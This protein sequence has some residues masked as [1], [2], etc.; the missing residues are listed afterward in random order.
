MPSSPVKTIAMSF[1][2]PASPKPVIDPKLLYKQC[3]EQG[4][5][6]QS[7]FG[8]ANEFINPLGKGPGLGMILLTREDY[9]AIGGDETCDL[10][11]KTGDTNDTIKN[12]QII[13]A[14]CCDP[15][16]ESDASACYYVEVADKRYQWAR[17]PCSRRYNM[18]TADGEDY[19]DDTVNGDI[20]Y[21][22][23]EMLADLWDLA[24][25]D[26][27]PAPTLD[28]AP[29]GTPENF[30]FQEDYALDALCVVLDRLGYALRW[31]PWATSNAYDAVRLGKDLANEVN[32]ERS[33]HP[34]PWIWDDYALR[35]TVTHI[36][37]KV[38]VLFR[39]YPADCDEARF[40]EV[41]VPRTQPIP[42]GEVRE[43]D[44]TMIIHDDLIA[45]RDTASGSG[46]TNASGSYCSGSVSGSYCPGMDGCC[47]FLNADELQA[48]A[49]ERARDF[50]RMATQSSTPF[51]RVYSGAKH[52]LPQSRYKAIHWQEWGQG[53]KTT[54]YRGNDLLPP[55]G[56]W[57]SWYKDR[58]PYCGGGGA[59]T[60]GGGTGNGG[61]C[62][63]PEYM[64]LR[65]GMTCCNDENGFY[66]TTWIEVYAQ[67]GSCQKEVFAYPS[68]LAQAEAWHFERGGNS[69]IHPTQL[70]P[71]EEA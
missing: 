35:P 22:W 4:V 25:Q 7:W 37:S 61:V 43:D 41:T 11:F 28:E 12:V 23:A 48:R 55:F 36:P 33:G 16:G 53:M 50:Y 49:C 42:S 3:L 59:G 20:P 30:D 31:T 71:A 68:E 6:T 65:S 32:L 24:I 40:C 21:T 14:K 57:E 13:R 45:R 52:Y 34:E 19:Q 10:V 9:D 38:T 63:A 56:A 8:K 1:G 70:C 5:P 39:I 62:T 15:G 60:S 51:Q 27:S 17:L 44:T 54:V 58:E 64:Q 26:G 46:S 29:H 67:D 18:V 47:A 66:T 2:P 69:T